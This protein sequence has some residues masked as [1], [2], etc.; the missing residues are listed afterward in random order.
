M[1]LDA[2]DLYRR[3]SEWTLSKVSGAED[4]NAKTP[5][6]DW[7]VRD[8]MNHMLDVQRYFTDS[9]SGKKSSM[10]N[11]NPPEL[12]GDDPVAS[13]E[14]GRDKLVHCLNARTGKAFWT[15]PTRARVDSSPAIASGRVYV[16]SNDG[17]FYVLDLAS[18][19]GLN[20]V[21]LDLELVEAEA[22][23]GVVVA[24]GALDRHFG[25]LPNGLVT[26][27]GRIAF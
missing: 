16:G 7:S 20:R 2:L 1:T 23:G 21:R 14:R 24:G 5:C 18:G 8:L 19:I 4:L 15:F 3:A 22:V 6:D 12:L 26:G 13:F 25:L 17:H 10:N 9:A 27:D 11:A